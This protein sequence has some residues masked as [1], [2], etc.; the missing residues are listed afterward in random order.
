M[1]NG[2]VRADEDSDDDSTGSAPSKRFKSVPSAGD[3]GVSETVLSDITDLLS[4]PQKEAA[5]RLG[6]SESMLCKRFKECTRRKWPFRYLRKIE[7]TISSLQSQKEVEPLSPEDQDRLDELLKQ[8]LE[9]LAPVKIR[10]TKSP[11]PISCGRSPIGESD[12]A[13]T[14]EDDSDSDTPFEGDVVDYETEAIEQLIK[15]SRASTPHMFF[16][17]QF[18]Y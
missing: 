8:R 13:T 7:K 2:E 1:V 5:Q 10:I 4:L 9:C 17:P 14:M 15:I 12:S 3:L 16:A 6:I 18:V 11:S